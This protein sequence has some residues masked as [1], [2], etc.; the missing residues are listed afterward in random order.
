MPNRLRFKKTDLV[1]EGSHRK[2]YRHP[3]VTTMLV[4]VLRSVPQTKQR[5][6]LAIWAEA[7]FP[8]FRRRSARKE[9][10]EYLRLM[11]QARRKDFHPPITHM[12]G[13]EMTTNGLGCLT[14]AVLDGDELGPTLAELIRDDALTPEDLTLFNDTIRRLYSY[15]IR[16]GDMTPRNFVFGQ[17]DYAGEMGPRE[18]VLVDGFGDIH[19]IPIR[20]MGRWFN[21]MGM[22]DNCR[23]LAQRTGLNWDPK[24]RQFS[25]T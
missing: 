14:E 9:Y 23:R 3:A 20:S 13:F 6:K 15:D 4:K 18:C 17:R 19:A 16:A 1:A 7:K 11:L 5:A 24:T 8:G 10:Q 12:Y 25:L 21:R 2:V 22:D